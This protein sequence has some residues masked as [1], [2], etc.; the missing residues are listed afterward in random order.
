MEKQDFS[1]ETVCYEFYERTKDYFVY[2]VEK[3]VLF[4]SVSNFGYDED[5]EKSKE[6]L[7]VVLNSI[8]FIGFDD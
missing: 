3:T 2:D 5:F 1:F 7:K 6:C 8:E 4:L